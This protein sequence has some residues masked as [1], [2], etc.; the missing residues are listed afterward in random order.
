MYFGHCILCAI[1]TNV[2][3]YFCAFYH[4]DSLQKAKAHRV[5]AL[6]LLFV[7]RPLCF[8]LVTPDNCTIRE[9]YLWKGV[10]KGLATI[11]AIQLQLYTVKMLDVPYTIKDRNTAYA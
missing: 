5:T 9:Q 8:Y 11:A 10:L 2:I 7:C 3:I 6:Y 1:M 4:T